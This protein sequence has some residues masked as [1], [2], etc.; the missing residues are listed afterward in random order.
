ML[1]P[2]VDTIVPIATI[3]VQWAL[4]QAHKLPTSLTLYMC[5]FEA[6]SSSKAATVIVAALKCYVWVS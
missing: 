3:L 5:S 2:Q 4:V 6:S 1:A